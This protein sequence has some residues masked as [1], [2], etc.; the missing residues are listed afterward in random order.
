MPKADILSPETDED[1]DGYVVVDEH[2]VYVGH[3]AKLREIVKR[4]GAGGIGKLIEPRRVNGIFQNVRAKGVRVTIADIHRV[5]R[6]RD[7]GIY[8]TGV[9]VSS[10]CEGED[11]P[12]SDRF[13]HKLG[14]AAMKSGQ[15]EIAILPGT[16]PDDATIENVSAVNHS[17]A[18]RMGQWKEL[19][20]KALAGGVRLPVLHDALVDRADHQARS[21]FE[22]RSND[23][24]ASGSDP[25]V[26][27][28]DLGKE[29]IALV[30]RAL[31]F[32]IE[33]EHWMWGTVGEAANDPASFV[34]TYDYQAAFA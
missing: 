27:T 8:L 22:R 30:G 15:K 21:Q 9:I 17:T 3:R 13:L 31:A 14:G 6:G 23:R 25:L 10:H 29:E 32:E 26:P 12:A 33:P 24:V 7:G 4:K 5:H 34:A 2:D 19:V 28:P 1:R 18:V 20:E 11:P 16:G